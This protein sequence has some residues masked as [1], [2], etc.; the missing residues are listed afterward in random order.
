MEPEIRS[1]RDSR[2]LALVIVIAV[3]VLFGLARVRFP[4]PDLRSTPTSSGPLERLAARA[5]YDDLAAAVSAVLQR[6]APATV[7]VDLVEDVAPALA[8]LKTDPRA[9]VPPIPP[10]QRRR[11][12]GVMVGGGLAMVRVPAG[13]RVDVQPDSPGSMQLRGTDSA[14]EV[15]LLQLPAPGGAAPGGAAFISG[16]T[17]VAVIE[18]ALGGPTARPVFVGRVDLVED[19][20]WGSALLVPGGTT[21]ISPGSLVFTLDGQFIGLAVPRPGD[22]G[23]LAPMSLLQSAMAVLTGGGSGTTR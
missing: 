9:Q 6:V 15:A 19:E 8:P 17:Y 7:L 20:R 4:A 16:F 10:P 23:G 5:S 14:R 11:M 3:A 13:F 12:L 2:L 21:D 22:A 1:G 18:P